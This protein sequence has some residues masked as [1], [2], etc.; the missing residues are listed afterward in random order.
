[1]EFKSKTILF[2]PFFQENVRKWFTAAVAH[3]TL[4]P[5]LKLRY[6][7]KRFW[8]HIRSRPFGY[9]PDRNDSL[10]FLLSELQWMAGRNPT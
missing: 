8:R 4:Y 7:N 6:Q 9:K 5:E 1:M 10:R 3:H 2:S